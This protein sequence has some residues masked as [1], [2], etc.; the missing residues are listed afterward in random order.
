M[1]AA[2][3]DFLPRVLCP[4]SSYVS[5]G[6]PTAVDIS[7]WASRTQSWPLPSSLGKAESGPPSERPPCHLLPAPGTGEPG[8]CHLSTP[9]RLHG[10]PAPTAEPPE[11]AWTMRHAGCR[12]VPG[13]LSFCTSG[14]FPEGPREAEGDL[15]PPRPEQLPGAYQGTQALRSCLP[16]PDPTSYTG[17]HAGLPWDLVVAVTRARARPSPRPG[18]GPAHAKAAGPGDCPSCQ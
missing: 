14:S 4:P 18:S 13:R 5:R 7:L 10:L 17:V 11:S 1:G 9:S 15:F 6:R 8:G 12:R 16:L 3:K 2:A